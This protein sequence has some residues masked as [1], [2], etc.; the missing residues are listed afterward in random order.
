MHITQSRPF[1]VFFALLLVVQLACQ[2][3]APAPTATAIPSDTPIPPTAT[4]TLTPTNTPR[5]SPTPR[6]TKTPNLAA[7]QRIEG[8]NTE[9]QKYFE[10][11]YIASAEGK[12]TEFDDFDYDWAQMSW[13]NWRP[14]GV[15]VADFYLSAHFKWTSAY[16]QANPSGC[17]FA[18]AIQD[19][20]DHYAI[21]L[22][23]N[24]IIFLD[25]D[26]RNTY[27]KNVRLAK[28]NGRVKFANPADTPQETDF[29]LLVNGTNA[30]ILVDGKFVGRYLLNANRTLKGDIGLSLLSG[31][32]KDFG[33]RCEMTNIRL[34]EP[35]K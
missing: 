17:G 35:K 10:D 28:G 11:G 27:S 3:G 20:T 13:Y 6:P 26:H 9:T 29:T 32:N 14:L 22:D 18:F 34:W 30:T 21:F 25:G 33:T 2:A 31:T 8:Y 12:I 24:R 16:R 1:Q 23:W 15:K 4:I 19:N 7:T 5:P